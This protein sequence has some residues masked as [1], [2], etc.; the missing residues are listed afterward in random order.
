ME[1]VRKNPKPKRFYISTPYFYQAE[2][3]VQGEL[4]K[5]KQYQRRMEKRKKKPMRARACPDIIPQ[6]QLGLAQKRKKS[7]FDVELT[8]VSKQAVINYRKL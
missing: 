8:N 7:N 5:S 6:S 4:E 1:K 2:E 3:R